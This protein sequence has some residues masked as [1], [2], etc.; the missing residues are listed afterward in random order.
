M[1]HFQ[2]KTVLVTGASK[3]IGKALTEAFMRE[4]AQVLAVARNVPA[5]GAAPARTD[6]G[7]TWIACDVASAHERDKLFEVVHQRGVPLDILV[8]NAGIQQALD[9]TGGEA[10]ALCEAMQ[11]EIAI[12]LAAPMCI[13]AMFAPLL[14]RPGGTIVNVTSLVALQAKTSA[15]AYSAAKAGLRAFTQALRRQM[16]PR[17][18]R[19]VEVLPPLVET[20][21]TAGRGR[22]KLSADGMAAAIVDGLKRNRAT[23]A[24]GMAR[25]VMAMNRIAPGLVS[26][27]LG[28]Q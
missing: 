21:M 3:G 23:I 8:N 22:G 24:P 20:A 27:L 2:G 10:G 28:G 12:D 4:G 6:G 11:R 25:T 26:R 5:N 1:Q 19:V 16:A 14:A 7:V 17:G 18:I 9:L 15:P 13:A